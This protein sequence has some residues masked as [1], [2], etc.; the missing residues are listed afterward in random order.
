MG[1]SSVCPSI[2]F[3]VRGLAHHWIG[4]KQA[5][6]VQVEEATQGL[7]PKTYPKPHIRPRADSGNTSRSHVKPFAEW[8]GGHCME[9]KSSLLSLADFGWAVCL[10]KSV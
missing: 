3:S 4:W 8:R 7:L 1:L 5:K 6:M 2:T 9:T 10:G